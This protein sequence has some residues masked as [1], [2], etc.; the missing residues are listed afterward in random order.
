MAVDRVDASDVRGR[1]QFVVVVVE[2]LPDEHLHL[3]LDGIDLLRENPEALL[4]ARWKCS[5]TLIHPLAW[6]VYCGHEFLHR[7]F[8]N[9]AKLNIELRSSKV[10]IVEEIINLESFF[11]ADVHIVVVNWELESDGH[12]L[13]IITIWVR[14]IVSYVHR[15]VV[16]IPAYRVLSR[17]ME[18]EWSGFKLGGFAPVQDLR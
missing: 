9:D 2:N 4:D 6:E 18:M 11:L 13:E 16:V 15:D 3:I 17:V 12:Q 8:F 10:E 1:L 7:D 14:N 5:W